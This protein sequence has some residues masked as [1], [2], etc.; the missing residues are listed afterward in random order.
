MGMTDTATRLIKRFGQE[1][2]LLKTG[3]RTGGPDYAPT[4]GP[5]VEHEVTVAVTDY[6][7]EQR[8][9]SGIADADL[10]VFMA[11][12]VTP[13]TADNLEIGGTSY[14]VQ[15]VATLGPDGVTICYE[16]QVRR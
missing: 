14:N 5:D 11:A 16:L 6:T 9:S 8:Q 4:F 3:E 13:T 2:T 10:R 15:R 7:I 12:G 1:A